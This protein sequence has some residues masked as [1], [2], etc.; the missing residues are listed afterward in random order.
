MKVIFLK[1]PI[2][3]FILIVVAD[4]ISQV[5]SEKVTLLQ[6]QRYIRFVSYQLPCYYHKDTKLRFSV[7]QELS[8]P[9]KQD[10]FMTCSLDCIDK[11]MCAGFGLTR[12]NNHCILFKQEDGLLLER[13]ER[14]WFNFNGCY[15][16][17]IDLSQVKDFR[18]HRSDYD[19]TTTRSVTTTAAATTTT[20]S[21]TITSA[22]TTASTSAATTTA[23]TSAATTTAS[24]SAATTTASTSAATTTARTSSATTTSSKESECTG[25]GSCSDR[26]NNPFY[27]YYCS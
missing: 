10:A 20:S 27:K 13:D 21:A 14:F 5:S 9:N 23:S 2:I 6:E 19:A 8:T 11:D 18:G 15:K 1:V 4:Y 16:K 3:N 22:T 17:V 12:Q 24:T 7:Y 25:W 26:C